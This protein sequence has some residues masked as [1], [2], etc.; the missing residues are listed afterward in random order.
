MSAAG[1]WG[2]ASVAAA[3]VDE[4]VAAAVATAAGFDTAG[5]SG[6]WWPA[7]GCTGEPVVQG[8]LVIVC[9]KKDMYWNFSLFCLQI[10]I[11]V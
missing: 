2:A 3:V 9:F 8:S 5:G 4:V 7:E 10:E 6:P 11:P 1:R